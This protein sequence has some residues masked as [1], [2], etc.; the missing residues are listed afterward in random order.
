MILQ[1]LSEYYQ[2]LVDE[3]DS[4]VAP[5]GYSPAK[6]SHVLLLDE[7]GQLVDIRSITVKKG[8]KE[9]PKS[10]LVP[11]QVSRT[12]GVAA[13]IL[14]DNMAYVLGIERSKQ[15]EVQGAA[16]KQ[17]DFKAK[18][19]AFLLSV[20]DAGAQA[21]RFF[22]ESWSSE[23]ALFHPLIAARLEELLA[24]NNVVFKLDGIPGY[25]HE[26]P[27]V[28]EAWAN[29]EAEEDDGAA[30]QC[31]VSGE[32]LS[33]A[34]I[35]PLIKGVVGAQTSGA[36]VV[37]FNIDSF[38]SYGKSQSYNAPVSKQAAFAYSTALNYLL[39]GTTNKVRL[40]N[41]VMVFW[42]DRK[43]SSQEEATLAW[44]LNPVMDDRGEMDDGSREID[45]NAARQAEII[46]K[47]VKAGLPAQAP[48]FD[49]DTRCYLL[50]LAPNAAR[51]AIRFWQVSTFGDIL[52]KIAHHYQ[53]MEIAGME[54]AGG[55]IAPWR[56]LKAL[57]VQE[58]T[59]NIPPLLEGQ[60][61]KSIVSGQ[62]Y[63]RTLYNLALNRC[64][65]GGERGGVTMIRAAVIKACLLRQY[66]QQ[67]VEKEAMITVSLQ[68]DKPNQ[69]YQ[70]G[71][72]FALLEK[73]QRD[74]LG[75]QINATIR[76]RYFGAASATPGAVFPLLLRLSRHHLSKAEF[77]EVTDRKIQ[78]VLIQV[79]G[80]PAH[81][82]LEDQGQFVL[83][84]YHQ[85]EQ[86]NYSSSKT[87]QT[88]GQGEQDE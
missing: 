77:G 39:V 71:R 16:S 50:G 22:L 8:S 80:F 58:D 61:I 72:L 18:N 1:S 52:G 38:T 30:G 6:V 88:E 5:P 82:T 76:D 12:S 3:E 2:R 14:C 34:R 87:N 47:N 84:Y 45:P 44:S 78:K 66:R 36:A 62:P 21:V 86:G 11:Q 54:R 40:A 15:G 35:H 53:D 64:R 59:G 73:A 68:E 42:G 17:A 69:A 79:D 67:D 27:A 60:L 49:A 48:D 28:R 63:P 4:G 41:M 29:R 24:G 26:L 20:E 23:A 65:T 33:L 55:W 19:I 57:A 46:L 75:R 70:L 51:L 81:L 10:L 9:L 31:L 13:N 32:V 83:G 85:K 43:G 56:I 37:S 7:A 25:I 74:A